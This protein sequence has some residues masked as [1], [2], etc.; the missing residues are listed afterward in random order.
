MDKNT[1][2]TNRFKKILNENLEKKADEVLERLNLNKNAKFNE[3]GEPFDYVNEEI[4]EKCGGRKGAEMTE[5]NVCECGMNEGK[6][7]SFKDGRKKIDVEKPYG[8]ITSSDFE[9]LR[10]GVKKHMNEDNKSMCESC[11]GEMIEGEMCESCGNTYEGDMGE[12]VNFEI[13][14]RLYGNQSRIDKNKNKRIDSE[15]FKMLRRGNKTNKMDETHY[16]LISNGESALFTEEEIVDMI[17]K[18]I[19]EEKNNIKIGTLP[20]GMSEYERVHKEDKKNEDQYFKD[21]TKKMNDYLKGS[22]DQGSKYEMK[23]TKKFP[24]ENGGMKKGIRK[25]YT[26]SDAVDD[27]IDA[28]SYPG[29]TNLRFDDVKPNSKNIEKYLKGDRTTGNAQV[30]DDGNALGNVVPSG[31]GEKFFKNFEENLY[32]HEQADASYKRYSQPVDTAGDENEKGSLKSKR[33]KKTAQSV[34]NNLDESFNNKKSI[35]LSEE[36]N[37]IQQLMSYN[38]KTQ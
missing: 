17:E 14:E 10:K 29:Q 34:L 8:K 27:Y 13:D 36:F 5:E 38:R 20:K 1:Y 15:D 12:G 2:I 4:C 23:E 32:G 26:P 22:S 3:P 16:R 18:I 30:D 31:V 19:K 35:M 24:T 9:K 37:K 21:L 11:G 25:K 7:R 33:G 6:R 28:F